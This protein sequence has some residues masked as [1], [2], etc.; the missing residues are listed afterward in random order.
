MPLFYYLAPKDMVTLEAAVVGTVD[1]A[2]QANWLCDGRVNRPVKGTSGTTSWS[3]TAA[4]GSVNFVAAAN[5][6]LDDGETIDVS[7]GVTATLTVDK[8]ADEVRYNP[9][10]LITPTVVNPAPIVVDVTGNSVDVKMGEFFAGLARELDR[11]T[12]PGGERTKE[13]RAVQPERWSSIP[14]YRP[15]QDRYRISWEVTVTKTQFDEIV[16]WEESTYWGTLPSVIVPDIAVNDC[17]VVQFLGFSYRK[18]APGVYDVT[19]N[20]LEFPRTQWT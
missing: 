9:W 18:Q 1:A 17:Y 10:A 11:G 5:V 3:I 8:R 19:L 20:F 14:G 13:Y 6:N 4:S 15:K 2:H 7:G 12:K 16:A